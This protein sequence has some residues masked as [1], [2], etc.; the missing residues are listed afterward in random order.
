MTQLSKNTWKLSMNVRGGL[1][2][3]AVQDVAAD[4]W[5]RKCNVL[6]GLE[7]WIRQA[8]KALEDY[9]KEQINARTVAREQVLKYRL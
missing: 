6:G 3:N 8:R 4:L 2:K 5:D 1:V 7:K 9:R